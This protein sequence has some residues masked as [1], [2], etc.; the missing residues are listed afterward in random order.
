VMGTS[1]YIAPEQARGRPVD[2]QSDIYSLG[3]V[4]YELLTGRTPYT[5]ATL[6]E[7]AHRQAAEP[8]E[9]I[10]ELAPEVPTA[11][12]DVVMRC[13]ARNPGYRPATATE[14]ATELRDALPA[15][16]ATAATRPLPMRSEP[17]L[18]RRSS[19]LVLVAA[20][21]AALTAAVVGFAVLATVG[22]DPPPAPARVEP[23]ARGDTAAEQARNLAAWLRENAATK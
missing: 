21:L 1:D 17:Q 15:D 9:P 7:L 16:R 8:I 10:R 4:L 3:A 18:P 5:F 6:A 19:R 22:D 12:E 23:V 11:V 20:A 13:L 14:I 2:A